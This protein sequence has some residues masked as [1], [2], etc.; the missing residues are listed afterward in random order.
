VLHLDRV[1]AANP[2]VGRELHQAVEIAIGAEVVAQDR[3]EECEF[4]DAPAIAVGGEVC[5]GEADAIEESSGVLGV[6]GGWDDGV[7]HR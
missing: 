5:G 6:D 1:E 7:W 3:A 4:D 2:S